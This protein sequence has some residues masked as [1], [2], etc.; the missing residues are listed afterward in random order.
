MAGLRG[1]PRCEGERCWVPMFRW[2]TFGPVGDMLYP[3]LHG[4]VG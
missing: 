3:W 4:A 2:F 1:L